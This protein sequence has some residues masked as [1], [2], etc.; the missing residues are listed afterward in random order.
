[1]QGMREAVERILRAADSG[2]YVCIYGDYDV[3]GVSAVT[4]LHE[5]L[6]AYGVEH[7]YF[8]PTRTRE[9]Y[10]L[11][12]RG[13]LNAMKL[14]NRRPTLLITVDCGTSSVEEVDEL[15]RLGVDVIILDHPEPWLS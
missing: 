14:C 9:G 10:G 8:I 7:S 2:E 5:V 13:I 6:N 15:A 12:H 1:M 4:L 3:D 11:S